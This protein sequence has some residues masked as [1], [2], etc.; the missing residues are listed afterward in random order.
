MSL[1][2]ELE[3]NFGHAIQYAFEH[4]DEV[5]LSN[6]PEFLDLTN[7]QHKL[8]AGSTLFCSGDMNAGSNHW[9]DL[10]TTLDQDEA[11]IIQGTSEILAIQKAVVNRESAELTDEEKSFLNN[12]MNDDPCYLGPLALSILEIFGGEHQQDLGVLCAIEQSAKS[13]NQKLTPFSDIRVYPNPINSDYATLSLSEPLHDPV[14]AEIWSVDAKL[15]KT[16]PLFPGEQDIAIW[17][18]ELEKG[19]YI[20]KIDFQDSPITLSIVKI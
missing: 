4:P 16:I 11:Q 13:L 7:P 18:S 6:L 3:L 1:Y 17:T 20:I 8:L 19:V 9:A 10:I 2:T 14:K 12:V 5:M 15:V